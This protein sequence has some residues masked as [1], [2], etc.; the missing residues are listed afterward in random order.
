MVQIRSFWLD[1]VTSWD[2]LHVSYCKGQLQ[3][4]LSSHLRLS[5]LCCIECCEC[6]F[7]PNIL[8]YTQSCFLMNTLQGY[9]NRTC[10]EEEQNIKPPG[11]S[12][13]RKEP[14][15]TLFLLF[16]HQLIGDRERALKTRIHTK[17]KLILPKREK[18]RERTLV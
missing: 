14:K 9:S 2:Q 10:E 13:N 4:Q 7:E 8:T 15:I 12:C 6:M 5:V 3:P 18:E 11:G 17:V 1:I 16:R